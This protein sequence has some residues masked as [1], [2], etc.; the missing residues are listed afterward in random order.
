MTYQVNYSDRLE[1]NIIYTHIRS[2]SRQTQDITVKII[3]IA[4]TN[5]CCKPAVSITH[6]KDQKYWNDEII[7]SFSSPR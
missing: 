5:E 7:P 1:I 2:N 6:L 4:V 3:I